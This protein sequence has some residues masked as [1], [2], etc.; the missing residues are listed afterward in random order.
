MSYS[1]EKKKKMAK[2]I[3]KIK[4]KEDIAKI[5]DLIIMDNP[6]YKENNNGIFMFF[7]KLKDETYAKIEKELQNIEKNK[8]QNSDDS[9]SS[10]KRKYKP[11][12]TNEFPIQE[13][14]IPK[15]RLTNAEKNI[16]KKRKRADDIN[17]IKNEL[18]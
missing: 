11:Y 9:N 4:T 3:Q 12:V 6:H 13:N 10:E 16:L 8:K 18:V 7:H 14:I 5:V 15:L 17:K 2:R 1:H